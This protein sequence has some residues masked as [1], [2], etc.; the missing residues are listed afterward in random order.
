MLKHDL[1]VLIQPCSTDT[2]NV[3]NLTWPIRSVPQPQINASLL[4]ASAVCALIKPAAIQGITHFNWVFW[5]KL[6]DEP[7]PDDI[8]VW[9]ESGY[10]SIYYRNFKYVHL[11]LQF[12]RSS[13]ALGLSFCTVEVLLKK[14]GTYLNPTFTLRYVWTNLKVIDL[15]MMV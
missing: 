14:L 8:I 15:L 6:F 1:A 7:H 2:N 11:S 10:L 4:G 9:M 13:N 3:L 12:R 5:N